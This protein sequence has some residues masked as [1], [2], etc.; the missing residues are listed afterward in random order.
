MAPQTR[1]L[2]AAVS[3][4]V[5]KEAAERDMA[6]GDVRFTRRAVREHAG[7]SDFQV[8]THLGR[9][10]DLEYVLVHRGGRGQ[11]F[12]YELLWTHP[13]TA[14]GEGTGRVLPGLVD[15]NDEPVCGYDANPELFGAEFEGGSSPQRAHFE[16]ASSTS[17]NGAPPGATPD[18]SADR[19][20]STAPGDD[21]DPVIGE[22]EPADGGEF[23]GVG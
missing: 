8:R 1:R 5:G 3:E 2:L 4:L 11:S 7:W 19:P 18:P 12:V 13:D 22:P 17:E 14:E 16:G 23:E 20:D 6:A 10:V 9:L 15:I 21:D